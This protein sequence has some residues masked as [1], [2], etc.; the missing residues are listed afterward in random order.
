MPLGMKVSER[1]PE[2]LDKKVLVGKVREAHGLKGDLYL[3]LFA[4]RADWLES[5]PQSLFF[6]SPEELARGQSLGVSADS[7]VSWLEVPVEQL[8]PHKQG[9]ILKSSELSN[10]T[11]AEALKGCLVYLPEELLVAGTGEP[12]FLHELLEVE[13]RI[14]GCLGSG[15]VRSFSSNGA[16]DLLCIEWSDGRG[17]E[18]PFVQAYVEEM[19]LTQKKIVL[20]LP[21]GFFELAEGHS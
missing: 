12:P 10:R 3:L 6:L 17:I 21:D 7:Q 9:L 11:A 1:A 4:G 16:Q 2:S 20:N 19:D 18:V 15:R 14:Q 8:S 5:S 13:V